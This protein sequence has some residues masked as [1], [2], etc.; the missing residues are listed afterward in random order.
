MGKEACVLVVDDDPLVLSLVATRL[1]QAGY[2]VEGILNGYP[3]DYYDQYPAR[4]SRV[5]PAQVRDVMDKFVQPDRMVI[6]VV[7]PAAVSGAMRCTSCLRLP[8]ESRCA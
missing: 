3:V 6:V 1:E 8:K 2:R 5:T 4:A 7:A